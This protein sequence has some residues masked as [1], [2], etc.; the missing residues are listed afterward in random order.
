MSRLFS[1]ARAL[2]QAAARRTRWIGAAS[3]AVFSSLGYEPNTNHMPNFKP[4]D[5]ST[6]FYDKTVH[7]EESWS[8][9]QI[10]DAIRDNSVFS[11]GASDPLRK[12]TILARKTEGVYIYDDSGNK[13]L[14]WSAQAVCSNLGHD[15][16]QSIRDA[17]TKQMA[18]NAFV[19][20]DLYT[21]EVRARLCH[22][23]GQISP[24][25][26]NGFLFASGG[27]EANEAAIRLARRYTGQPKVMSR[28]RSYHGSSTSSLAMTGDPRSWA[29]D[30]SVPGFVKIMDPFPFT[31]KWGGH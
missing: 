5:N 1:V 20:G 2:P 26:L 12:S 31:F 4:Q 29:V 23:L 15:V 6:G 25:D 9:Q 7:A 13:I 21:T 24:A 8:A 27:A 3:R 10:D 16:P 17:V 28:A 18:E 19:Y 11:W 30:A 14:D 22:L